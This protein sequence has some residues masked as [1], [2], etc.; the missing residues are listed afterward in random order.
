MVWAVSIV[1]VLISLGG[2]FMIFLFAIEVT[3][4]GKSPTSSLVFLIF[5]LLVLLAIVALLVRLLSRL[6]NAYL[7]S[8]ETPKPVQAALSEATT[9]LLGEPRESVSGGAEQTTRRLEPTPG[10]RSER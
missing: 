6:I 4:R 2:L 10:E 1:T 9:A 3:G 5:A 7:Q 8:R